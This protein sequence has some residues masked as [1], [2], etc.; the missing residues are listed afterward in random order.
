[1]RAAVHPPAGE[2]RLALTGGIGTEGDTQI[3]KAM[4]TLAYMSPEQAAGRWDEVGPSCDLYSLGA[5]LFTLLTGQ[6]PFRGA[7]DDV[8]NQVQRGEIP[9]P[10]RL[11]QAV[12]RPLEAICLK[13][14]ALKPRDRYATAQDLAAEVDNWLA[15]EPV[16]AS[17]SACMPRRPASIRKP[18]THNRT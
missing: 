9:R 8:L 10:W 18:S 5:T 11:K 14:M 17:T 7:R 16:A 3:G 15:G 13:A 6:P 2:D 12:P 4:G 1:M